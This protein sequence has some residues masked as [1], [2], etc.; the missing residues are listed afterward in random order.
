MPEFTQKEIALY[1]SAIF[2][3]IGVLFV[4]PYIITGIEPFMTIATILFTFA[5]LCLCMTATIPSHKDKKVHPK[6]KQTTGN[7]INIKIIE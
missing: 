4:V 1:F 5:I 2:I 6:I 7:S 3:I